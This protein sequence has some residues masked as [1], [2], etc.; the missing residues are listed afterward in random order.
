M[1]AEL[2]SCRYAL[3]VFILMRG[4]PITPLYAGI[5]AYPDKICGIRGKDVTA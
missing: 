4:I 2:T 3:W 1:A 5:R